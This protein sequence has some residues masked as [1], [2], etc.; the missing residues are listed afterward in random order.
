MPKG[1][2]LKIADLLIG[3][4]S[5]SQQLILHSEGGVKHFITSKSKKP[6]DYNITYDIVSS[7]DDSNLNL[8]FAGE[9]RDNEVLN[10]KWKV[11]QTLNDIYLVVFFEDHEQIKVVSAKVSSVSSMVNVNVLL[12]HG[13]DQKVVLDPLIHPLGSLILLYLMHW[14]EALLIHASGVVYGQKA[15]VFTGVSGIGKS[16][17]AKLWSESGVQVLNDDRLVMR[18]VGKKV[19]VY[20]NPMP[21]Y[22]Q[23][24]REGELK[25]IFLLKQSPDN[26][27]KPLKGVAA[28]SRVL[29]NFIQ[30]FYQQSMVKKHLEIVEDVLGI[31][32]VYEV[33]FKPDQDIVDMIKSME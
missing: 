12:H 9:P 8:V 24:P 21:Y 13:C 27:I 30:Q 4:Q 29:G 15:F 22:Q 1:F 23:H 26:Y 11:Y 19:M 3:C 28:Y 17:M 7:F 25:K 32:D 14:K 10:Y 20:N 31:V 33:G 16:T 18:K 2:Y 6:A 5:S